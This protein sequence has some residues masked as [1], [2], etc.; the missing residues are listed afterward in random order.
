MRTYA[1]MR[2]RIQEQE[3]EQI[4]DL[5]RQNYSNIDPEVLATTQLLFNVFMIFMCTIIYFRLRF[6][7]VNATNSY[8]RLFEW[9]G[10]IFILECV[11]IEFSIQNLSLNYF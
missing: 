6:G 1:E 9:G 3:R 4:E 5:V 10:V 8:L 11:L 2:E 7:L